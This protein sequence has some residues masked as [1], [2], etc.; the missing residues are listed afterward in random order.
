MLKL[1]IRLPDHAQ[2]P[3]YEMNSEGK[4]II[5]IG[6]EDELWRPYNWNYKVL[7]CITG[8]NAVLAGGVYPFALIEDG[9]FDILSVYMAEEEGAK[10]LP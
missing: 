3:F 2:Y 8:S 7:I 6:N 4:K 10:L 5:L 9:D 1:K